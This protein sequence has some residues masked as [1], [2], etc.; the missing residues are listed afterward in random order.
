MEKSNLGENENILVKVDQNNLIYIDPNSVIDN[1]GFVS[2]RGIKQE[3]LVMYVNLEAD[4]IPRS[5]LTATNDKT[6]F[7]SIA[8]GT[9]NFLK[10]QTKDDPNFNT[11]WTDSFLNTKKISGEII[12]GEKNDS[13][14]ESDETG[15]SFGMTSIDIDT[16]G[17]NLTPVVSISFVD[18][19]GKTLFES[20]QNSPYKAFFHVPWPIFYLTV[21]GF[22]GKAIRYR[23]HLLKFSSKFNSE[24]GNFEITTQFVG[25]TYAYLNDIPLKGMLNAPYMYLVETT[26]DVKT[27]GDTTIKTVSRSSKGYSVLKS[28]YAEYKEKGLIPDD[29]PV[30]TL[31]EL[32][33]VSQ[34]LDRLW[35]SQILSEKLDGRIFVGLSEYE[36]TLKQIKTRLEAWRNVRLS[37]TY[38]IENINGIDVKYYSQSS[39][40]KDSPIYILGVSEKVQNT[41]EAIIEGANK[42]LQDNKIFTD[43]IL[44]DKTMGVEFSR[45]TLLSKSFDEIK[46]YVRKVSGQYEVAF[47][48]VLKDFDAIQSL[49]D[50]QKQK[51]QEAVEIKMNDI[52]K[53]K[54]K[55]GFGFDPTIRNIFA[56][57]L[58]NADTYVRLL[59]DVH[60]RAFDISEER[61][62]LIIGY[63]DE[64]KKD[65]HIYPWPEIKKND[66][67]KQKVIAYPGDRQLAEVLRSY[68]PILWPEV[69]F[70]ENY[71]AIS[72]NRVDTNTDKESGVGKINYVFESDNIDKN[73]IL[74]IS[75]FLSVSSST[76]YLNLAPSS[77]LYEIWERAA[78][79]TLIDGF[80]NK[81]I[82]KLA[83][84]EFNNINEAVKDDDELIYL[85]SV[86]AIT[87][88]NLV[89]LLERYSPYE[90]YQYYL[91]S[92]PTVPYIKKTFLKPYKIQQYIKS[93][94]P[95]TPTGFDVV[96]EN[97]LNYDTEEYRLYVYPFNSTQYLNYL[98][99]DE[100]LKILLYLGDSLKV[101][102]S[103]GFIS[104]PISPEDWVTEKYRENIFSQK[105]KLYDTEVNILN[106]P[107]FHKQLYE[108]FYSTSTQG[109]FAGSAYLLLNSLPFYNLTDIIT[110]T[111]KDSLLGGDVRMFALFKEIGA[112]HYIPYHLI[113][114]WGSI[115]HR[116][117]KYITEGVDILEGFL[118]TSNITQEIPANTFFCDDQ[119]LP[120]YTAFTASGET[121]TYSDRL[122]IG[123]HPYYDAIFH[124]IVNGYTHYDVNQ[125]NI[126]YSG[127]VINGG[128]K[129]RSRLT[130]NRYK[131]W[132]SFVDNSKY[133]G[134]SDDNRYTFLPCDG[135]NKH[136]NRLRLLD[137]TDNFDDAF[138]A[139]FRLIWTDDDYMYNEFSGRTFPSYKEYC[140]SY[141]SGGTISEDTY[142]I[143]ENYRKIIDLIGI[144][145][146]SI[147]EDFELMFLDF[148]SEKINDDSL[149]NPYKNIKYNKFQDLLKEIVSVKKE[150]TDSQEIET[151]IYEL[152]QKQKLNLENITNNIL[153][154]NNLIKL[155]LGNPKEYDSYVINGFTQT[156]D[157]TSFRYNEYDVSQLTLENTNYIKLYLGED[158]DGYYQSF[159]S[160]LDIE[161][162]EDN[163]LQFRSLILIYAGY[164][165]NGGTN[166]ITS[167]KDYLV[168]N[169]ILKD[170][171][172]NEQAGSAIRLSTFLSFLTKRFKSLKPRVIKGNQKNFTGYNDDP[173][174]VEMYN[175]FKT[176]N[177]KWIA[178][179]SL[180]QRLLLEE[181]LFLD[182]AN[183]DIGDKVFFNL[184]RLK[185]LGDTKNDKTNLYGVI[186][187]LLAGTGFDMRVLPAYVN[188]YGTNFTNKTKLVP[189]KNV[190]QNLFGTFLDVDYQESTPKVIIQ[191]VDVTSKHLADTNSD[192]KFKDDSYDIGSTTDNSIII[193]NPSVFNNENLFKSNKVVAFEVN[194]GDQ[195]QSIFKG[196]S[197]DQT[198]L[199]NTTE[200]FVVLENLA[201]SASGAGAYNVDISLYDYYRQ[202]SYSCEVTMMGNVMIQPT[203][204]FYLRNIPMF[205]GSYWIHE[206]KH[207]IKNNNITTTFK[208]V[209]IP[210]PQLPDIDDYF[211]SSYRVLF[212]RLMTKTLSRFKNEENR[213]KTIINIKDSE[214]NDFKTDIGS[215]LENENLPT[216]LTNKIGIDQFGLPYNGFLEEQYIQ[217][218][219]WNGGEWYRTRVVKI[220]GPNYTVSDDSE[221][222]IISS[223]PNTE[224]LKWSEIKETSKINNFYT[225]KF[226]IIPKEGITASKI[227]TAKT[228]FTVPKYHKTG[229]TPQ[230]YSLSHLII[231]TYPNRSFEGQIG[232]GPNI[233]G[234][235]MAMSE[236][237]MKT[238][239]IIDGDIIYFQLTN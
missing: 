225:T 5:T 159:F 4:I 210:K 104:S 137:L 132:T 81:T 73:K 190:A 74:P 124:Q 10:N 207:S 102:T 38:T 75:T 37:K 3:N 17:V 221:F 58:A 177:D 79:I 148:A 151:L 16:K 133:S 9:F 29:F 82:Y 86:S 65:D 80:N 45:K 170:K 57:I 87:E 111:K 191:L 85:L 92:I 94:N 28:V 237:L 218:I 174:K 229:D 25:S 18:V 52:I 78:Q 165:K 2:Q 62:K 12:E 153:S 56:V 55:G 231:G 203:M 150:T 6:S 51:L 141:V 67:D 171:S 110:F 14:Y 103:E 160:S 31:R 224:K 236:H 154:V 60:L 116:Y 101:D 178:G 205:R 47:D 179:N 142:S 77:F 199:T 188:F 107:Y 220:D 230:T 26:K 89:M 44:K 39:S 169:I 114:K 35:E 145:S 8:K 20:P 196:I 228:I 90:R 193:T 64:T 204:F 121:I 135:G 202:A 50:S 146:P 22:Y 11:N 127:N 96:N 83:E 117:K 69:D 33:V 1:D 194:F 214:G 106:T 54:T 162:N 98:R 152:K 61:K 180:G 167:F 155:T 27:D 21:K 23:L 136:I 166:N 187:M 144:F 19:R 223:L 63:S 93:E 215:T 181:F 227:I 48:L 182:R 119:V 126:S 59:K 76:P 195:N 211:M 71:I 234:Y 105:F 149:Y 233:N 123:V 200:G 95:V 15:Q 201:R 232:T 91:D 113:L 72:T 157:G 206:V 138:Q 41:L 84:E 143:D 131:Y 120:V 68:D 118:N 183:R 42:E 216:N 34:S 7:T 112:S 164:I 175:N 197:L 161:L 156:Q 173:L 70:V 219:G 97:L 235:G 198:T 108:D 49:Y 13:Y 122:D 185:D 88:T 147:L 212:D 128:I 186:S 139:Y 130:Q 125:G 100:V 172:N 158:I 109:K 226:K 163:I 176:F 134:H 168:N 46:K 140:L 24:S 115:Y 36:K 32:I 213:V 208:G 217:L 53:D 239:K 209:R 129:V 40:E 30:K 184:D 99:R 192:Y 43:N 189:S 222:G 238:L 66:S